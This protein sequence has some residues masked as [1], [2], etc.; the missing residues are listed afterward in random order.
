M[1]GEAAATPGK[2]ASLRKVGPPVRDAAVE[3]GDGRVRGKAQNPGSKLALEAVHDRQHHD[4][5]GDAERESQDGDA[6]DERHEA[7]LR[8]MPAGSSDRESPRTSAASFVAQR[9]GG[10]SL[11]AFQGG[12]DGGD[13]ASSSM[14]AAAIYHHIARVQLARQTGDV[15]NIGIVHDVKRRRPAR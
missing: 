13:A 11:E 12:I 6:G 2:C 9:F 4:E 10:L 14:A 8:A 15:V 7:A 5:H 1:Y 3:P